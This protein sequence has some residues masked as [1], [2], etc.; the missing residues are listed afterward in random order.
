M[1]QEVVAWLR[2]V[3]GFT[4]FGRLQV[5]C[6]KMSFSMRRVAIGKEDRQLRRSL[7]LTSL[8][9][10]QLVGPGTIITFFP[11]SSQ[12]RRV[13]RG[14]GQLTGTAFSMPESAMGYWTKGLKAHHIQS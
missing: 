1:E 13:H 12:E 9:R 7:H 2:G 11:W 10:Q 5:I 6:G 14:T 4:M 3:M 8:L